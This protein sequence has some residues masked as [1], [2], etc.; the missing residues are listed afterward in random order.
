VDPPIH[1][2]Y[3]WQWQQGDHFI[4][5][6]T[7]FSSQSMTFSACEQQQKNARSLVSS[8]LILVNFL[9]DQKHNLRLS[10]DV[11]LVGVEGSRF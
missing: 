11:H 8:M 10:L 3:S 5:T 7:F 6:K 2:N 4:R 1:F 9:A